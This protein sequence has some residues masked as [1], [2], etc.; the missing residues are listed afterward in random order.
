MARVLQQFIEPPRSCAYLSGAVATLEITILVDVNAAE[1]EALL[2]HGYRHFGATYFRPVCEPCRECVTLRIPTTTFA[3]SRSQRRALRA[4]EA[5]RRVV[6]PPQVDHER[7]ALYEKWHASREEQRGWEESPMD[8]ARYRSDFARPA[9]TTREVAFY[10]D[11]DGG[12]LVGLGIVDH[13]TT[14]LSA[15]YFFYDPAMGHASL[16]TA[17][18]VMLVLEAQALGMT[19][20]YLGYRVEGCASLKYKERFLPHELLEGRPALSDDPKWRLRARE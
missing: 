2:A 5:F 15:V 3:P 11:A 4:A 18:V 20:V 9:K 1:L 10:D 19:H 12:R 17:H 13:T 8:A 7:L 6:G 16:G 14:A